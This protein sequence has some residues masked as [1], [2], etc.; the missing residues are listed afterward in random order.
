M[1]QY[2]KA[3]DSLGA[4]TSPET[5][6]RVIDS[7]YVN[8]DQY[9]MLKGGVVTGRSDLA[10]NVSAGV[11]LCRT[12]DGAHYVV[13]D[14]VQTNLVDAPT[15]ATVYEVYA[16]GD[17][18]V[19]M[20]KQGSRPSNTCLIDRGSLPAGAS[21]TYSWVSNLD[22]HYA[23]PYGAS[24]GTLAYLGHKTDGTTLVDD[25]FAMSFQL[26]TDR[27]IN[28]QVAQ[29]VW[30]GTG[31]DAGGE[32]PVGYSWRIDSGETYMCELYYDKFRMMRE[33]NFFYDRVPAGDHVMTIRMWNMNRALTPKHFGSHVEA[34]YRWLRG[35]FTINDGGIAE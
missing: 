14:Y 24:Y 3:T 21:N 33:F 34:G 29:T 19:Y 28:L 11:G 17:G 22:R 8:A 5:L 4:Y 18:A 26:E 31:T 32:G 2:G 10:L 1:P 15:S 20:C 25:T 30:N 9:P 23:M 27:A 35:G 6:Q 12:A 13:W 7:L 16:D